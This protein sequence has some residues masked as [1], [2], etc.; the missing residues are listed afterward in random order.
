MSGPKHGFQKTRRED[1]ER[2]S[3]VGPIR[4]DLIEGIPM[5]MVIKF[6]KEYK[7]SGW[8]A[9]AAAREVHP[10]IGNNAA[11]NYGRWYLGLL[12]PYKVFLPRRQG[13]KSIFM[14]VM[15]QE[16]YS[17]KSPDENQRVFE[18]LFEKY[19]GNGMKS[20]LLAVQEMRPDIGDWQRSE[21]SKRSK[22]LSL[23]R[24]YLSN[25]NY[26]F[27]LI[28]ALEARGIDANKAADKLMELLNAKRK[29]TVKIKGDLVEEVSEID[30][31]SIDK[32]LSHILKAGVGGGYAP[33]RSAI[34]LGVKDMSLGRALEELNFKESREWNKNLVQEEKKE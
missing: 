18:A 1:F 33:E 5:E 31:P 23:A 8:N 24:K 21:K 25:S 4:G 9:G 14:S 28:T 17:P 30:S 19:G 12:D 15:K 11:Y 13:E 7:R 22:L 2:V 29:R 32:A 26:T 3:P 34:A 16:I 27:D 20:A 10:N 6:F